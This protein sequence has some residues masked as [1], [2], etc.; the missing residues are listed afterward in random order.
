[1]AAGAIHDVIVVGAGIVGAA[2][3]WV[4]AREGLRVLVLESGFAGGG[5]T[6]TAMGHIV[7]MDDSDAQFALTAYS[8][9]LWAALAPELPLTCGDAASGT[10]W[11]AASEI[12]ME[13][14]RRRATYYAGRGVSAQVL[15]GR[16]LAGLEPNLR[17]NLLGG[18]FVPDDRVVYPP[19]V[20]RWLLGE[21]R[22]RGARFEEGCDVA[23]VGAGSVQC[24]GKRFSAGAVINAAGADAPR[25]TPGLPIVPRKGHLVITDRYPGFCRSQLIELGYLTSAHTLHPESVAFNLHP[26]PNGQMIIGS[27]RELVGWD[28]T[29]N[30][31]LVRRL[32]ARAVEYLPRLARC[33]ALRTWI[34]FRP[35]TPD[36][37]PL[38]GRW[39]PVAGL[40]IAAGHEGLGVAMALGTARLLADQLLGRPTPLDPVPYFPD[41]PMLE[42]H[43]A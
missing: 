6:G 37:L 7:T 22:R 42:Q 36:K 14:V 4:L 12:E 23:G 30:H 3:A 13:A 9:G 31:A 29:I 38:I 15:D 1:M 40:W 33:Q 18:L 24:R 34:G 11:V 32:L 10:L 35:A 17:A 26:R 25:L 43:A 2:C 5:A 28:R 8:R 19:G 20:V 41:R 16:Q 27:S 21:A 39:P